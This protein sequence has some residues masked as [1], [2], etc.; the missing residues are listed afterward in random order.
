[1]NRPHKVVL[2]TLLASLLATAGGVYAGTVAPGT[3]G[4]GIYSAD[5]SGSL[6]YAQ[7][8]LNRDKPPYVRH[9]DYSQQRDKQ[10][11]ENSE[12]AQF[13]E[14]HTVTEKDRQP[15]YRHVPGGKP[16]Y[17]RIP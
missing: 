4:E 10:Q 2:K 17:V 6:L 3:A 14:K 8:Y 12:F 7:R 13:E 9:S 1:M 15:T 11:L 16:P 5:A